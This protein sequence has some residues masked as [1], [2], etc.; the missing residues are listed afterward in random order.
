MKVF[1]KL[2]LWSTYHVLVAGK[3][4]STTSVAPENAPKAKILPLTLTRPGPS[5][6]TKEE[7]TWVHL[8]VAALYRCA[9]LLLEKLMF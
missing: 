6:S 3:N 1:N 9:A 4:S 7:A 5:L 2:I 8:S